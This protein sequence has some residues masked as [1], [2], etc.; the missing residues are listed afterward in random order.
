MASPSTNYTA[1]ILEYI[2]LAISEQTV[3]IKIWN[4]LK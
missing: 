1:Q 3:Y 4:K 2:I